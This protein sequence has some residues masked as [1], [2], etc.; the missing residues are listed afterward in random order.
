MATPTDPTLNT[1]FAAPAKHWVLDK[2]GKPNG[3][4]V[5]ER[6]RPE[7]IVAVATSKRKHGG[8]EELIFEDSAVESRANDRINA[9][10]AEVDK[11]RAAPEESWDVSYET[12]R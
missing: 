7:Y 8:Q 3:E 4:V 5:D 1:P 2:T 6:R 12:A 9:I 11:W 10:R